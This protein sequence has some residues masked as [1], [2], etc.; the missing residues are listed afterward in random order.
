MARRAKQV[1]SANSPLILSGAA[2]AGTVVTTVLAGRAGYK[3]G[4]SIAMDEATAGTKAD[5]TPQERRKRITHA[6]WK[7]YFSPAV[8]GV[9]TI[10]AIAAANK[11]GTNRAAALAAAYTITD[12]A[13]SEYKD[14]VV[15]TLGDKKEQTE[16][17]DKIMQDRMEASGHRS[18]L[19][20]INNNDVLCYDAFSDRYFQSNMEDL[21]KAQNDTNYEIQHNLYVSLSEFYNR[22]GLPKTAFSDTIG[23]SNEGTGVDLQFSTVMTP[24]QRPALAFSFREDPK[25][26]F[27]RTGN[28]G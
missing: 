1:L 9:G 4:Y 2:I 5:E 3:A 28:N 8:T 15:D 18:A 14:K 20:V 17:H 24:D 16:I 10:A 13:Y 19:V 23:W 26:R 21:K 27:W 12:K 7:L 25:P 6:T 22:V 11:I